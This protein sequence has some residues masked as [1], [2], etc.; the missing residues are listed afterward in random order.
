MLCKTFFE[1]GELG[2]ILI[3]WIEFSDAV[4]HY[5]D[6]KDLL[7]K[8]IEGEASWEK[9]PE[10]EALSPRELE[11]L[12]LI[13]KGLSN[14]DIAKHLYITLST[15]K[16]TNQRLFAKLQVQRRTEAVVKGK[17]IGLI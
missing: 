2:T 3:E 11:V 7:Y 14:E 13:A 5:P 4:C 9:Q 1:C 15:V 12:K 8:A 6:F 16:G 10:Y 17:K